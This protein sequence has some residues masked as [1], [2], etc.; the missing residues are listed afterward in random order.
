[1]SRS[2]GLDR[3]KLTDQ[4][5]NLNKSVDISILSPLPEPLIAVNS[6]VGFFYLI[7]PLVLLTIY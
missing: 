4:L 6:Y 5:I 7:L 2:G 1:M 3:A